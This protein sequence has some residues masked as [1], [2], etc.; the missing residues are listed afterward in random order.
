MIEVHPHFQETSGTSAEL[1]EGDIYSVEQ[2]LYG[3]MLPSGNDAALCLA[4]WAGKLLINKSEVKDTV[5]AFVQEMN[6]TVK[7]LGLTDSYFGNPHGLPHSGARSTAA[8]MAR[9]ISI[10]LNN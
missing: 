2:L 10:C 1:I 7:E 6:K 3:M 4:D 8:D 5:K 9:L